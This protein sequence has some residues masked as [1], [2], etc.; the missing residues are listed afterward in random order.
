MTLFKKIILVAAL[1]APLF[2]ANAQS[3]LS[4]FSNGTGWGTPVTDLG[5]TGTMQISG[6][7]GSYSTTPA[8]TGT[9]FAHMRYT[10]GT[11]SYDTS[12]SIRVDVNYA[13]PGNIFTS[14]SQQFI[15]LGLMVTPASATVGISGGA[16]TFDGFSVSSD[17]FSTT[18]DTY[19]R[20]FRTS[21]FSNGNAV[22]GT[23]Y[24]YNPSITTATATAV[25]LSYDAG[26]QLL[27]ASFDA[28]NTNGYS[29][30]AMPSQS[31]NVNT[32]WGMSGSDTF[33]LYVVGNSGWDE[34]GPDVSP[35]I[36]LG[37]AAFD[38]LYGT[39]VSAIPEPS[40]YAA[41]AGALALGLAAWRR[42]ARTVGAA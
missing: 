14:G 29:F 12:W 15:N 6:G 26:T 31:V 3:V 27:T 32:L 22:D 5:D 18:S 2:S 17:L 37:E 40:T 8:P 28:N 11:L 4:D 13:T 7:V 9:Q 41:M 24:G 30:T 33:S 36:A 39:G 42:R 10:G 21:I 23:E 19:N 34:D 16:P 38:N 25:M 1:F 35:T 20:G